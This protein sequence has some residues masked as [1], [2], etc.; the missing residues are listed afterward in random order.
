MTNVNDEEDFEAVMGKMDVTE[1]SPR[2]N[3]PYFVIAGEDDTLSDIACTIEHL[4]RVPGPKTLMMFAGE[5]H[6]MGGSRSSQLGPPFFP[7]IADWLADRAKG[8]PLTSTYNSYRRY[9]PGAYG[10][11]G[12][13]SYLPL[14]R[15]TRSRAALLRQTSRWNLVSRSA[16]WCWLQGTPVVLSST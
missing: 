6:G 15:S 13:L 5:E 2:L 16:R 3:M 1:L 4:N 7:M 14:R 11:L 9:G 8:K 10:A 12:S